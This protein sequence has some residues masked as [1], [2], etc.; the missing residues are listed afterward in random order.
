MNP[1]DQALRALYE[2]LDELA[3]KDISHEEFGVDGFSELQFGISEFIS[4]LKE[5]LQL[6]DGTKET[7]S[8]AYRDSKALIQN[9]IEVTADITR[10]ASEAVAQRRNSNF[11]ARR[12][13]IKDEFQTQSKKIVE[14]LRVV[15]VEVKISKVMQFDGVQEKLADIK[16]MTNRVMN[17]GK[18]ALEEIGDVFSKVTQGKSLAVFKSL[19]DAHARYEYLWLLSSVG[20]FVVF[21]IVTLVYVAAMSQPPGTS[22][23]SSWVVSDLIRRFLILSVPLLALRYSLQHYRIERHMRVTYEHH[24]T[25]VEQF[26]ILESLLCRG[27]ESSETFRS[28]VAKAILS[29]PNSGYLADG[30]AGTEVN[31][32]NLIPPIP[33]GT[34]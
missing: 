15:C 25:L 12:R 16:I 5:K 1:N 18:R 19:R 13:E 32:N 7:M 17:E 29:L 27:D 8:Y 3:K 26:N 2:K 28:E 21:L 11:E 6:I 33:K 22:Q 10:R 30:Q 20:F 31:L 9:G 23:I 14:A 24:M 4:H 34:T